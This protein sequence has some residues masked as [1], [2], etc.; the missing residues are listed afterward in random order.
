MKKTTSNAAFKEALVTAANLFV[1]MSKGKEIKNKKTGRVEGHEGENTLE[2]I[3]GRF[4]WGIAG[5][6][7][8]N[9]SSQS[10]VIN[11][12]TEELR[13]GIIPGAT[14]GLSEYMVNRKLNFIDACEDQRAE[15]EGAFVLAKEV[16]QAETGQV[17]QG[18]SADKRGPVDRTE[19][20][21]RLKGLGLPT[22]SEPNT[23]G[24][25]TEPKVA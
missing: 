11:K 19:V 6:C 25:M 1:S 20:N 21:D 18:A 22:L 7:Q 10:A 5:N 9:I 16:Y 24:T 14:H 17:W 13:A 12:T 8:Y 3:R 4:L 2:Y 15:W 23:D